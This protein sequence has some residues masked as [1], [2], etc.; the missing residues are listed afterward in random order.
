MTRSTSK[1]A[2]IELNDTGKASTKRSQIM[3]FVELYPGCSRGDI[4]RS[5]PGMTVNCCSGRVRELLDSGALI[6]DGCAHDPI[7]GRSVNRLFV[8]PE[9]LAA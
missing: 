7:T 4:V 3:A 1:A 2:Y 5:I 8:N 6:E 9:R